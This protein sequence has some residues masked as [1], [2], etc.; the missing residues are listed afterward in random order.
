MDLQELRTRFTPALE[1]IL[2]KCR[3][4]ADLVDR[5]LFQVYMA[6]I[7][8]NVV[9]DPQGSG[10]E[11][12]DL[13]SLHDFLNEEIE[14]VLGKGVDVTS[15]YDFIASKQGNESLER[16]GATSDH[17]EFLHYFARL[18]LGKEVQAKP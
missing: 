16:L 14:R 2:G 12:Q 17:K 8:G 15:C 10:L 13:S 1:E 3:I 7:W 18:I 6:T 11:E 9:L 4:S 5:E